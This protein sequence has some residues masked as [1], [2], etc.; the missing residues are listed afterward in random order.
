MKAGLQDAIDRV[1]T[2]DETGNVP[3]HDPRSPN[4]GFP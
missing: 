4:G 3:D 2:G 1:T